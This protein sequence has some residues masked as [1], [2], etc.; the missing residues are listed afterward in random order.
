L[1]FDINDVLAT[2]TTKA[3]RLLP[4]EIF[5]KT[6]RAHFPEG[7]SIAH[8]GGNRYCVLATGEPA[9]TETPQFYQLS[10]DANAALRSAGEN[11]Y[12]VF[13]GRIDYDPRRHSSFDD[14]MHEADKVFLRHEKLLLPK[15]MKQNKLTR[16]IINW[17][18][19]IF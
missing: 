4:G 6:L 17:R 2:T 13:V 10:A 12:S 3:S 14:M 19:T 1:L 15:P 9:H 8:L 18:K 11:S 7:L 5:A 16:A